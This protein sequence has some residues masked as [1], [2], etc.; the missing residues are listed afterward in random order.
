MK[1]KNRM[2]DK[3]RNT[4]YDEAYKALRTNLEFLHTAQDLRVILLVAPEEQSGK[5]AF[6]QN[7]AVVLASK[8]RQV[9]LMDCDLR[10]GCPD[11]ASEHS[12]GGRCVGTAGSRAKAGEKSAADCAECGLPA[13]RCAAADPSEL[14]LSRTAVDRLAEL[15]AEYD[16]I[17]LDAPAVPDSFRSNRPEPHGGRCG[18]ADASGY[19]E[20]AERR[21]LQEKATGSECVDSGRCAERQRGVKR[22]VNRNFRERK[23]ADGFHAEYAGVFSVRYATGGMFCHQLR[24]GTAAGVVQTSACYVQAAR[25]GS[26]AG[27]GSHCGCPEPCFGAFLG[28]LCG[29]NADLALYLDDP[30]GGNH[31]LR[32]CRAGILP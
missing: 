3:S 4:P 28:Q 6:V 19:H 16:Y 11:E 2:V 13:L 31:L 30:G 32:N 29:G 12:G 25:S 5:C 26:R 27:L 21:K 14:F 17:I 7:L 9:L 10:C 8:E 24:V 18:C 15:R 20:D 22:C 23:N 1:M